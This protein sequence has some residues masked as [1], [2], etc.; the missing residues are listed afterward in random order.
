MSL[1]KKFK[2]DVDCDVLMIFNLE[3]KLVIF[4]IV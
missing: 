4:G 1:Y 2:C 3:V